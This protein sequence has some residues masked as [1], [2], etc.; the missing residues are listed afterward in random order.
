MPAGKWGMPSTDCQGFHPFRPGAWVYSRAFRR[1][2][3]PGMVQ[4]H[5]LS[6]L[7]SV[8]WAPENSTEALGRS[9][10]YSDKDNRNFPFSLKWNMWH[11]RTTLQSNSAVWA[12]GGVL[13]P[14]NKDVSNSSTSLF[15]TNV[16]QITCSEGLIN[17]PCT[18]WRNC[19]YLA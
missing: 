1:K 9:V 10:T 18:T 3:T 19:T 11:S 8:I 14:L 12:M 6:S 2:L 16:C 17:H 15:G 7:W 4:C 5:V 13:K